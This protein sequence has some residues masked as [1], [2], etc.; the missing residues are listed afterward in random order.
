MTTRNDVRSGDVVA[1]KSLWHHKDFLRFWSGET[2]S[3]FGAQITILALPLTAVLTLDA[4]PEQL[5]ILRFLQ[6]VP[7]L[8]FGPLLGVW[9]DRYRRRTAM[10]GANVVRMVLIGMVPVLA[11][12]GHLNMPLLLMITF[13]VGLAA[14]LFDISWM[15]FIP[16]LIRDP[17]HLVD[18]NSK[19]AATSATADAAGPGVAGS[20]VSLLTAPVAMAANAATYLGS[21]ISLLLIRTEE[22]PPPATAKRRVRTELSQ[23][24]RFV[25]G[26]RLLRWIALVGGM[27]NFFI[28]ATVPMFILFAVRDQEIPS[29]ALG[30]IFSLGACGGIIGGVLCRRL[31]TRLR[32]GPVYAG[33]LCVAFIPTVLLPAATGT[34]L[35][36]GILYTIA[37]FLGSLGLTIVNIVIMSVRQNITPPSL[38][39][40]MNAAVRA[41]MFGLGAL[42]GLVAGLVAAEAGVREALWISTGG[43]MV[44]V[45]CGVALS[46]LTRLRTMPETAKNPA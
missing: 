19:L 34:S 30:L 20:L 21:V 28:S 32:L 35:V 4:G 13:C 22:T 24:L 31:I 41:V 36:L 38:L 46:P 39:G 1:R 27:A 25:A 23:G 29:S 44:F 37:W 9:V 18:A 12:L 7:Y 43:S 8:L 42:G 17:E 6:M 11:G 2:F 10:I 14:V 5:G 45:L 33:G 15:S 40:R 16:T 26:D 3:L